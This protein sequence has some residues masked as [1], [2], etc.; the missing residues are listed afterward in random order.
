MILQLKRFVYRNRPIKM[1]EDIYFPEVLRIEDRYVSNQF[2][3]KNGGSKGVMNNNYE[4]REYRLFSVINHKGMEATKG[5]YVCW[6]LDSNNDWILYDD[7]KVKK[8]ASRNSVLESQA[9]LLF[10]EKII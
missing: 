2:M 6:A 3:A 8:A 10:Y 9:Y 4:G 7:N 5:H 1:K